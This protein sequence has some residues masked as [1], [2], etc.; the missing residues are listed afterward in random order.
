MRFGSVSV[1]EAEGAILAHGV[2]HDAGRFAK[3]R[4]IT[5]ADIAILMRSGIDRITVARLEVG[6]M[7]EDAAASRVASRLAGPHLTVSAAY[8]GRVNL[9]AAAD[10]LA[11]VEASTI[12]A[13]NRVHEAVTIATLPP[14]TP[15]L[16]G[17]MVAT[18]K[19]IPFAVADHI[20]TSLEWMLAGPGPV[21][22]APWAG[23]SAG[24]IQTILPGSKSSVLDKSVR[25]TRD[26]LAGIGGDLIGDTRVAHAVEPLAAAL[27][28]AEGD[29]LLVIGASAITDR[30]DVVPEAIMA[31]GG[32]V[33]H[34][35]M[36]VDPGNLLLLGTLDGRPVLGLPG[37]ARS[38]KLNGVDWALQRLGAGLPVD[39]GA[40]MGMGVGGLLAEVPGRPLPRALATALPRAPRIAGLVLA[41]GFGR[42]MGGSNK[43]LHPWQGKPLVRH[44]A[45]AALAAQLAGVIVA[46]GH[47]ADGVRA[48]LDGLGLDFTHA[49]DHADGLSAT[50]KAGLA[51]LPDDV[52]GVIVLLG[53]MPRVTPA[54]IDKL[55]AAFSPADGRSILVPTCGGRRGNPV[56]WDRAFVAEM[57]A[58]SG[59]TGARALLVQHAGAV[60]EVAVEDRGVLLD[61]DTPESL[62]NL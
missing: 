38:P 36:P 23:L 32:R 54:T 7:G 58:L 53:D 27:R 40:I 49:P 28:A 33:L 19:I 50:L 10:G 46:T 56:L 48:A 5:Q 30:R 25:V 17:Q 12:H 62:A 47:E 29:I 41:G 1:A 9:F 39:A 2:Q 22:L 24:L 59:D 35:G 34:L 45:D 8:T 26:R 57:M 18:I 31:A 51:A 21:A 42:R 13:L 14:F 52:D 55:V 11:L 16:K 6:D 15:V 44:V 61:V 37:C 60:C 4:V 43:L 20:I 3:G